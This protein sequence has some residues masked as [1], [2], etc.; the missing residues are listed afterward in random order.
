MTFFLKSW[1]G[2]GLVATAL[3]VGAVVAF[4]GLAGEAGL[5][6]ALVAV[7]LVAAA[8]AVEAALLERARDRA[9]DAFLRAWGFATA[10]KALVLGGAVLVVF[11]ARPAAGD[12]FVR[13]LIAAFLVFSHAGI[14]RLAR[15]SG[16]APRPRAPAPLAG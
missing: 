16:R 12:G 5:S 15:A 8:D 10:V 7:L 6:V 2:Y 9:G 11:G 3:S 4:P 14:V 1:T 13:A